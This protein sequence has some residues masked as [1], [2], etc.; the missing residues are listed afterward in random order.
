MITSDAC[1][2]A[3]AEPI[4]TASHPLPQHDHPE[5]QA[6][7]SPALARLA[8]HLPGGRI[9]TT[10]D[11]TTQQLVSSA[12]QPSTS[13][14]RGIASPS[15]PSSC[16]TPPPLAASRRSASRTRRTPDI[17]FTRRPRSTGSVI[18]PLI[19]ATAFD[20]GLSSPQSILDDSPAAWP[21]Y[22]PSNYDQEFLGRITAAEALAQSRNIP[23][24]R[25]LSHVG[26]FPRRHRLR[27]ARPQDAQPHPAS[28]RPLPRRRWR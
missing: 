28:L 17:D 7:D 9:R 14:S 8:D 13:S 3:L 27:I 19:Y 2:T 22:A 18:K 5:I 15:S 20:A 24:L 1:T 21:G 6:G 16:S 25:L 4:D 12:A 11:R 26:L 23:A 10:L